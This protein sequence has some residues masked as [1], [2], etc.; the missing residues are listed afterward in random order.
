MEDGLKEKKKDIV[1]DLKEK[2]DLKPAIINKMARTMHKHIPNVKTGKNIKTHLQNV[3]AGKN[4]AQKHL[5]IG[6][7]NAQTSS[8]C[9]DWLNAQ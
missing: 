7:A 6:K 1:D 5:Q 4:N 9:Q 2:Y 3:E 8:E